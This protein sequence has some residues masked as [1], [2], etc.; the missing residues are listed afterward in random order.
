[1]TSIAMK[2]NLDQRQLQMLQTELTSRQKSPGVAWLL[3]IFGGGLGAHRFYLGRTGS[4][5]AMLLTAG[6][7]GL[8]TLADLFLM[9]GMI[10]ETN[11]K[12]E[13]NILAEIR[14]AKRAQDNQARRSAATA[15]KAQPA[16]Q[17]EELQLS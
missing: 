17:D 3:L 8:W 15:A 11:E 12:I 9:S 6:L 4:G 2:Q 5:I 13:S 10:K 16:K 1:M 14:L 7:L